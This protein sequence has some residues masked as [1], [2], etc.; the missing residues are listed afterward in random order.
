MSVDYGINQLQGTLHYFPS[1]DIASFMRKDNL[2]LTLGLQANTFGGAGR[3]DLD[4]A[5]VGPVLGIAFMPAQ[6]VE[7]NLLRA[8]IDNR[9]RYRVFSGIAFYFSKGKETLKELR[10]RYLEP[11]PDADGASGAIRRARAGAPPPPPP[12]ST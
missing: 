10:R 4:G 3:Q 2:E 11:N 12:P 6:G 1:T 8:T 7:V 9:S 5:G